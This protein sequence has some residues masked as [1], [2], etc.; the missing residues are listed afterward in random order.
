M[1]ESGLLKFELVGTGRKLKEIEHS[2]FRRETCS[3][4]KGKGRRRKLG[5]LWT[6]LVNR[7]N[8]YL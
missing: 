1:T 3:W 8:C 4:R 5:E 2:C 6:Y 7:S